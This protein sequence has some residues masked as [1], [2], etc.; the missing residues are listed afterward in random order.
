MQKDTHS[1][2]NFT[3][4]KAFSEDVSIKH[5]KGMRAKREK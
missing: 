3:E 2:E 4:Y 5:L 1:K